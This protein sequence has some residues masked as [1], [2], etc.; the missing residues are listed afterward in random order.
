[1][2][3]APAATRGRPDGRTRG[4]RAAAALLDVRVHGLPLDRPRPDERDL[5]GE[6]VDRLG[7]SAQEALHLRAA[8]DLERAHRVRPWISANTAGSS[9]G[10][11]ER[12]IGEPCSCAIRSTHSS[13]HES[14]P[15]PSRSILRKP[16][17]AHESLSHW[18]SWRPAI[19][20]GC[21]GTSSTSGRDE[22]TIPPGCCETCRGRPAISPV[23]IWNARQRREASFRSASGSAADLLGDALRV[24]AVGDPGEP[25]ELRVRQPERLA[26][27]ADRAARAVGREAGDERG[28]LAPVALGDGDDQLLADVAREVEV[29]VG[30]GRELA[31]QEAAEREVVLHRVDVREAG[32]VADDRADRAA[33]PTPRRQEMPRRVAAAHL[34]RDLPRELEHLL[35]EQEEPR[36]P[37]LVDQRQLALQA[38]A[39]ASLATA[40][41]A[42]YRSPNACA[43]TSA[44][45]RI[46]GSGPS[47]KSG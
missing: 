31:V 21:T 8:L 42:S 24:P 18:Q 9:S 4:P 38:C 20:A 6:V 36:E 7:P 23:S 47:E 11:R 16:A 46:A 41:R 28:V 35:V 45:R 44:S 34:E 5:D 29:D 32:Q 10:I 25:L 15:S 1:M 12:S 37:E 13:M 17:S 3:A 39:R 22:I 19:A 30:H 43:H 14:I 2:R 26:D 40:S 27:V 33:S